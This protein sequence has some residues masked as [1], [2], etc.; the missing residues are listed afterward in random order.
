MSDYDSYLENSVHRHYSRNEECPSC[1]CLIESDFEEF[2][3]DDKKFK[4][5]NCWECGECILE[6]DELVRKNGNT[7]HR[8][9][10]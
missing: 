9:C 10:L 3:W 6:E 1:G 5:L 4:H 8:G 2:D 7:V